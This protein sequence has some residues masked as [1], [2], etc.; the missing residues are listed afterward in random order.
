M[1]SRQIIRST[2]Y[3][4]SSTAGAGASGHGRADLQSVDDRCMNKEQ[5]SED[6]A[7][8]IDARDRVASVETA[9]L[10]FEPGRS[11]QPSVSVWDYISGYEVRHLFKMMFDSA[12]ADRREVSVPFRCDT[13]TARR[14]ME[15]KIEP[16][17][18]GCLSIAG[19][20]LHE[21]SRDS[22]E[23]L[24]SD[25]R[26]P[27]RYL[28]ICSWCKRIDLGGDNW[29]EVEDAVRELDLL[30]E[31]LMPT[32]NHSVCFDCMDKVEKYVASD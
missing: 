31:P 21:E 1:Q 19:Q 27:D 24:A 4:G 15:L 17:D 9:W 3:A 12:R 20:M 29:V 22:V 8:R 16:Q 26:D 2:R 23:L 10:Q 14:F 32:L 25:E 30:S 5:E 18:D 13:P 6:F 28:E 7:Y 11:R